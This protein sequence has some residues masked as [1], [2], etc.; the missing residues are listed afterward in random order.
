MNK[1]GSIT[2]ARRRRTTFLILSALIGLVGLGVW[3][4]FRSSVA[5]PPV[6]AGYFSVSSVPAGVGVNWKGHLLGKTPL[7]EVA[8]PPGDQVIELVAPGYQTFPIEVSIKSGA[9]ADLGVLPLSRELGRIEFVTDPP[10]VTFQVIGPEKKMI[11]GSTPATLENLVFGRYEITLSEPGWPDYTEALEVNS[12]N[13]VEISHE[14]KGGEVELTSD[15]PGSTIVVG[16]SKLGKTPLRANLPIGTVEV[17]SR[18]GSLVPMAQTLVPDSQHLISFHF[19]HVYGTLMVS[20]DRTDA[21]LIIDGIDFGH[22][23]ADV[24]L[25]PGS[26]KLLLTAP[27]APDKTRRVDLLEGQHVS[28]QIAFGAPIGET[29]SLGSPTATPTV[30]KV[31]SS[32]TATPFGTPPIGSVKAT[33]TPTPVA[34]RTPTSEAPLEKFSNETDQPVIPLA[35]PEAKTSGRAQ[36]NRGPTRTTGGPVPKRINRPVPTPSQP[37]VSEPERVK[38]RE[39]AYRDLDAAWRAKESALNAQKQDVEYQIRH[40][41]GVILEQWKYRLAQWRVR[42]AQVDQGRAAAEAKFR[43]EWK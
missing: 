30:G 3:A 18:F 43:E 36:L 39:Q 2:L 31:V 33:S 27:D 16:A 7:K 4:W 19:K 8:L 32:P 10:G 17:T 12:R 25:S 5:P 37:A 35:T 1:E 23:P 40:S 34:A 29:V 24:F 38:D 41:T 28:V 11:S 13:L 9:T 15:P 22:P 21:V 20:S 6:Q 42:K 14:F 26:H